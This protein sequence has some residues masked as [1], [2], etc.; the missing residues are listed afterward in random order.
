M[1]A[2]KAILIA[3]GYSIRQNMWDIP[4]SKL[5]IWEKIQNEFTIGMNWSCAF[6]N[7]TVYMYNDYQ[8][9]FTQRDKLKLDSIPLILGKEDGYYLHKDSPKK[10]DNVILLKECE[11]TQRFKYNEKGL[12]MHPAYWGKDAWNK[13]FFCSQLIGIKAINLAIALHCKEIYLL[14]FDACGDEQGRT[15]FYS[16]TELGK[17]KWNNQ[18]HCGVGKDER[19]NYRTGNFNK[20]EELN[21]FWFEP[22]KQEL[23]DGIEIY[24]ISLDSKIDIFPKISYKKFYNRLKENPEKINH[25]LMREIIKEKLK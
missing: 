22:F 5:P 25:K 21:K 13:G 15:H 16:D 14:G 17:Y 19:G 24:N 6:F 7:S 2:N 20:I 10:G 18:K 9:Y 11:C 8:W 4:I 12:G 1:I 23:E 3:S